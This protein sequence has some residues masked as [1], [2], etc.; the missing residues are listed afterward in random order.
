[1]NLV[2]IDKK[3]KKINEQ[4][5]TQ[6]YADLLTA[7]QKEQII[8][9]ANMLLAQDMMFDK[10]WD[11]ER[12][13]IPYHITLDNW[14]IVN[15]DDEEWCFMLNRFDWLNY[16][17]MAYLCSNK[18][19]YLNKAKAFIFSWIDHHPVIM[20]ELSTRTLDTAIRAYN[21]LEAMIYLRGLAALSD[22]EMKM[23]IDSLEKQAAYCYENYLPKYKTSNWGSIQTL[24]FA[25]VMLIIKDE[26]QQDP[27]YQWIDQ[28]LQLQMAIQVYPDG[29]HW[30]QSTMYHAEVLNNGLRYLYFM[31]QFTFEVSP[32]IK[33]QI[34]KMT[35]CLL[36]QMT[37]DGKI[38]AFG[39]SDRVNIAEVFTW[40]SLI[41]NDE[42]YCFKAEKEIG[43]DSL[44]L[45][46]QETLLLKTMTVKPWDKLTYEGEDS[47]LYTIR[48]SFDHDAS[49][50]L[51]FNGS[52]GS[53]HGHSDNLHFSLYHQGK[54]ILID[55]GRYT[56]R[57][58]VQ[59]RRYLKG[60]M[61]HNSIL[62]DGRSNCEVSD[63]WG[64]HDFIIPTKNYVRTLG[65]LHYLEGSMIMHDPLGIWTR[66]LVV[67][68]PDIWVIVDDIKMDG[69]HELTQ[70]FH[71]DPAIITEIKGKQAILDEL[72]LCTELDLSKQVEPCSLA[73]NQL[74]DHDVIQAHKKFAD[75]QQLFT[76]I[77]PKTMTI[78]DSM[79]YQDLT[80][81]AP[82]SLA[83]A[84]KINISSHE[85]Y[86]IA[87]F[88][89]EVYSGK[90]IC[91][92]ENM[93]FHAKCVI[94]H[95]N[96]GSKQRYILRT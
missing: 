34:I 56:Y 58:D 31:Q 37:P 36:Y 40:A 92:C 11:M 29:S 55:T 78:E 8:K 82:A 93:C 20:P 32:L 96:N 14:N 80:K 2:A 33:E 42:R 50:T 53:G 45:L 61:G 21:F 89:H 26:P 10:T 94:I 91:S 51:F 41:L 22:E 39:D 6:G 75:Q 71:V 35:D 83:Q 69:Q 25:I 84:K 52:L 28:E 27:L 88:H 90:K 60:I 85:S 23:I 1:M 87:I 49:Y 19:E 79:V 81:P 13:L 47:G 59:L 64:Y 63:S 43:M 72:Q 95:D 86:T 7:S 4:R 77:C 66:K 76:I 3:I 44:Y 24:L 65:N 68:D 70:R 15:N 73:Y 54:P 74:S 16:L 17:I 18:E 5:K 46:G 48:S 67:I 12:C 62:V 9:Q 38:D 30:E 57:E